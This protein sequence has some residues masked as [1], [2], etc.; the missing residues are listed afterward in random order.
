MGWIP[1]IQ[2]NICCELVFNRRQEAFALFTADFQYNIS[3]SRFLKAFFFLPSAGGGGT[4]GGGG[5]EGD[6]K[7]AQQ[8]ALRLRTIL[9]SAHE[10]CDRD[11]WRRLIRS[12]FSPLPAFHFSWSPSLHKSPRPKSTSYSPP[13]LPSTTKTLDRLFG[14]YNLRVDHCDARSKSNLI[15]VSHVKPFSS[16]ILDHEVTFSCPTPAPLPLF[17][18]ITHLQASP[19]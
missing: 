15:P 19:L 3:H 9:S 2:P 4:G 16:V 5:G 13:H 7:C 8:R 17:S 10:A 12:F 18:S 6:L 14:G 1:G 11:R